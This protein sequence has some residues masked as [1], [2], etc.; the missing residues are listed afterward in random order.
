M[1]NLSKLTDKGQVLNLSIILTVVSGKDSMRNCLKE[2]YPQIDFRNSEV[3]VPYDKWSQNIGGLAEEFPKVIFHFIEDLGLAEDPEISSHEH[4]LYDRRRAIGLGLATG[5]IIAITEDHAT[6]ASNWV[7]QILKA[8]ESNFQIIGGAIENGIDKSLNWAWYYCDFGRYGRPFPIGKTEYVSDVNVSYKKEVLDRIKEIWFEAYHETTVH[9]TL[10][11]LGY[12][13]K[14][15][16][17]LVVFQNRPRISIFSAFRERISWGRIF[18]ETRV[19]SKNQFQRIFYALGTI[20]LPFLLLFR[21]LKN[22]VRQKRTFKQIVKT[23]PVIFL[24]LIG[25]SL[26]EFIGY[27]TELSYIKTNSLELTKNKYV[28]SIN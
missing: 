8:H 22:M 27:I 23:V 14:L 17:N 28:D 1:E 10:Q 16:E 21:A 4:R 2:L 12:E 5:K 6:P 15:N 26:G 13:L 20:I 24:L 25:W 18:A 7:E 9:W 19:S 3:I 11:K